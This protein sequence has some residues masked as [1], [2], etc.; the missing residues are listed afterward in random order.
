MRAQKATENGCPKRVGRERYEARR[1][2]IT[3]TS[4]HAATLT[5]HTRQHKNRT[6]TSSQH[7][8]T[9]G[10]NPNPC[11]DPKLKTSNFNCTIVL[12]KH[13]AMLLGNRFHGKNLCHVCL[14][15]ASKIGA[16]ESGML[17]C[18]TK[19]GP[20]RNSGSAE[21]LQRM[22]EFWFKSRVLGDAHLVGTASTLY[23]FRKAQF[24]TGLGLKTL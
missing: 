17:D 1:P 18:C 11:I 2:N 7:L 8:N 5:S 3:K 12:F 24:K 14:K 19:K 21:S 6:T 20:L 15:S 22:T 23:T 4:H 13:Q 9:H 16:I 10:L